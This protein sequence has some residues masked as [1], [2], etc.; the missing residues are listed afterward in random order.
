MRWPKLKDNGTK[1]SF[2]SEREMAKNKLRAALTICA[3]N[4]ITSVVIGDF[5]LGNSYRNPPQEMAELWREVFLWDP[6]LRGRIH[7]V[8]FAFE[9]P[10]QSTAK[11]ILDDIA[12]KSKT[13]SSSSKGKSKAS[14]S[15]TSSGNM[16][17]P[18]D[19][20]I[21]SHVFSISEVNRVLTQPDPRLGLNNLVL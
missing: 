2:T 6:V 4:S 15:H 18:T 16:G 3:W 21:Y 1:Y 13:A 20:E 11:L 10:A 7:N 14:S 8:T 9:D 17:C 19:Q 5:G 12:K